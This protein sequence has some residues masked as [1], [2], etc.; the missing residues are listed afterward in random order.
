M[1]AVEW[2]YMACR[3]GHYAAM[4]LT[5]GWLAF[6]VGICPVGIG[7]VLA[8]HARSPLAGMGALILL[9]GL[10]IVPLQAARMSGET[11]SAL[12]PSVWLQVLGTSFG[13]AWGV[14]MACVLVLALMLIA[15]DRPTSGWRTGRRRYQAGWV[16]AGALLLSA[17]FTGHPA[18]ASGPLGWLWRINQ[19]VHLSAGAIWL[20]SLPP[21]LG[22]LKRLQSAAWRAEA[23]L[24]VR[25]FSQLG[26]LAVALV[27]FS[28]M[29]NTLLV[30][31][32]YGH[33]SSVSAYLPLLAGKVGLVM[34]MVAIALY[35]R[36]RTVRRW[37]HDPERACHA[38]ALGTYGE[39]ALG[40]IVL[41]LAVLVASMDPA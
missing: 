15:P 17:A 24:A 36:Y 26:H 11:A 2:A 4:M 30:S 27:L 39:L 5:F 37:G 28:G 22:C 29:V 12:I 7:A 6:L 31:V 32:L 41:L 34:V 1:P 20:G 25:R 35:N 10:L 13:H 8:R 40:A 19:I 33:L 21:V 3:W 18:A 16:V 14:H 9:T 38:L 23:G